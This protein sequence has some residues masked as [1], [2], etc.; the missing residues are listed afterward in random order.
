VKSRNTETFIY[1]LELVKYI[2]NLGGE[3]GKR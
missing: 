1:P 2:K 3:K